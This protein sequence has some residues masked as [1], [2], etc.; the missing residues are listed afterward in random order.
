MGS[1][2]EWEKIVT[3]TR[4]ELEVKS[5][6]R[7]IQIPGFRTEKGVKFFFAQATDLLQNLVSM[8]MRSLKVEGLLEKYYAV[9][10]EIIIERF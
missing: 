5:E 8:S 7:E 6:H 2:Q 1:I 3:E 4:V 9:E 10:K